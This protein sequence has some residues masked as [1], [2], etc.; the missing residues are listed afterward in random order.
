[1]SILV[2][3]CSLATSSFLICSSGSGRSSTSGSSIGSSSGIASRF[4]TVC[5]TPASVVSS[6]SKL[7]TPVTSKITTV[8]ITA[9]AA[10]TIIIALLWRPS[11]SLRIWYAPNSLFLPS[12]I[13]SRQPCDER[14]TSFAIFFSF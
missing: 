10:N 14:S 2:T 11:E 1:M 5:S 7:T 9:K 4:T 3:C 8:R 13:R 6:L 12:K